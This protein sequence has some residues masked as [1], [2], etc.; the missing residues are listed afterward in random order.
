MMY[1]PACQNAAHMRKIQQGEDGNREIIYQCRNVECSTTFITK[2]I[3]S[4]IVGNSK[5]T[6]KNSKNYYLG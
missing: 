1:C 4:H 2:E 3:L 6:L 5:M